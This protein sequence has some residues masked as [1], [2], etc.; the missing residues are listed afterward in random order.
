MYRVTYLSNI[1]YGSKILS[2]FQF[3]RG[4]NASILEI[5]KSTIYDEF[6]LPHQEQTARRA[7]KLLEKHINPKCRLQRVFERA[8]RF[9][10]S[11]VAQ[12][13]ARGKLDM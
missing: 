5:P 7:I 8:T 13:L 11:N 9:T 6:F 4:Y 12:S 2:S 10:P 1:L 3:A